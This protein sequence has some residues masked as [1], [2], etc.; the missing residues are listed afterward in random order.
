M[1]I[2][3]VVLLSFIT[4]FLVAGVLAAFNYEG[5]N[6]VKNYAAGEIIRGTVNIS[7]NNERTDSLVKSNFNGN[8]TLKDLL[9]ANLFSSPEDYN[10]STANCM[11][12]Y[13]EQSRVTNL[14]L[15]SGES[16][17][18]GF[19]VSGSDIS[20][21][22]SVKFNLQSDIGSSCFKQ[23]TID[24]LN[25]EE[26]YLVNNKYT[27]ASCGSRTYGCF[28]TNLGSYDDAFL[29]DTSYCEKIT[30][31]AGPAY[32]LGA[33]VKN[34]TNGQSAELK[35]ELVEVEGGTI[36]GECVLPEHTQN[37]Q[38]LDCVVKYSS[39]AQNEYLVC[40]SASD[41]QPNYIIRSE[42]Q[43]SVCGTD[44]LGST[45]T[46]DYEI[47]AQ[48]MQFDIINMEINDSMFE[49]LY[50]QKLSDYIYSYVWNN[51]NGGECQL[52]CVIPI[53]FLGHGQS[54]SLT[55]SNAQIFYKAGN[56]QKSNNNL[57][58]L[59][60][61]FPTITS[62]ELEIQ[63]SHANFVI[64]VG[65]TEN[66]FKLFIDNEQVF[67]TKISISESF[68]FDIAPKF[69]VFGQNTLFTA[70]TS[71]NITRSIWSFG[72]G[73]LEQT[74]NGK[75]LSYRYVEQGEFDIEVELIR[76]DG[77]RSKKTFSII[78]G[79]PKESANLTIEEYKKRIT[80][81]NSDINVFPAWV[82]KEIEK[83]IN[84]TSLDSSIKQL[85][86]SYNNA[87]N[88]SEF[89]VIMLSLLDLE[90]PFAINISK[91]GDFPLLLGFSNI[92]V[93]YIEVISGKNVADQQ[94]LRD[95]IVGWMGANFNSQISFEHVSAFY[96]DDVE[97]ILTKFKIETRPKTN[98]GESSLILGYGKEGIV[99]MSNYEAET[100]DGG[101]FISV[102]S[103]R[104]N[105]I[106]EFIVLDEIDAVDLGAYI[107]PTV[108]EL[109]EF[110]D[111]AI[112]NLNNVCEK[113]KGE[114]WKNCRA[115][116]KPWSW[117]SFWIIILLFVALVIYIILQEWYKRN[118]ERALFKNENDMYN[119]INFIYNAR[120]GGLSNREIKKKLHG[121]GWKGERINYALRKIDGKRIGMYEIP[122]F[123]FIENRKVQ[124][125]IA[126]RQQGVV[127]ARFIKRQRF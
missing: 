123:K 3:E 76:N 5:N 16:K 104:A 61:E 39:N 24:I 36:L 50:G 91:K 88:N 78:V 71:A 80:A 52:G 6:I 73:S 120:K 111:L 92:D 94:E 67:S 15:S 49:D 93:G 14:G 32:K 119:L 113:D 68:D 22:T 9:D 33:R 77:V 126:K 42:T 51:F 10:C 109:G 45:Y 66:R 41:S 95:R 79:D 2:L 106:F 38:D 72:D 83:Q 25:D 28:D 7:F 121:A 43:P 31:P 69:V 98:V 46:I 4:L 70:A 47:F 81:L 89:Q 74:V 18:V 82:K 55:F 105:K 125:E 34:S 96:D 87:T 101:T 44:N 13:V 65:A 20:E 99:F 85:E 84:L 64:P 110:L 17:F 86:T 75:S 48:S 54:Q 90:I 118:Y 100:V 107:S 57:Y 40:I 30:L 35:M 117:F 1:K 21:I 23:L 97:T 63:L 53:S 8:I 60:I 114:D 116:C 115:D 56:T 122:V 26:N 112:C 12:G 103:G 59:E 102:P 124:K 58:E 29:T 27:N 11:E 127:D 19:L 108:N 62:G 37:V